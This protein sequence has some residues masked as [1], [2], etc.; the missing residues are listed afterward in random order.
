M[1][2]LLVHR[3]SRMAITVCESLMHLCCYVKNIVFWIRVER[4]ARCIHTVTEARRCGDAASN[5]LRLIRLNPRS[6]RGKFRSGGRSSVGSLGL[7]GRA[8]RYGSDD[9]SS[10]TV[11]GVA[12]RTSSS[13]RNA[14]KATQLYECVPDL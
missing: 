5:T 7:R 12:V 4:N 14:A 3:D 2:E 8:R 9:A 6:E 1:S 11:F 13:C 10:G